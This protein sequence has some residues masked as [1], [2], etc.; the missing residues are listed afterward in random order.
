MLLK[1][2]FF[3]DEPKVSNISLE[4]GSNVTEQTARKIRIDKRAET[5]IKY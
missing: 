1:R 5:N 4:T 3:F 2:I